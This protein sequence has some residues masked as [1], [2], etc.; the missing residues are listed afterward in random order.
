MDMGF[1]REYRPSL[2]IMEDIEIDLPVSGNGEFDIDAMVKDTEFQD[3]LES[4]EGNLSSLFQ[5]N[6]DK[7]E[8]EAS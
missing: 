3:E 7:R 5:N 8:E 4:L 6:E 2:K 1:N